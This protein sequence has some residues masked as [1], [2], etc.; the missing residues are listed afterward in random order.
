MKGSTAT[1]ARRSGREFHPLAVLARSLR[2]GWR[3]HGKLHER[4]CKSLTTKAVHRHRVQLRKLMSLLDL[5]SGLADVDDLGKARRLLKR[6]HRVTRGLRDAQVGLRNIGRLPAGL[7]GAPEFAEWLAKREKRSARRASKQLKTLKQKRLSHL[8]ESLESGL[9][10]KTGTE[11]A[12]RVTR[13]L[14]RNVD[15][16]FERFAV[17]DRSVA[18][19]APEAIHSARVALKRCAYMTEE[20]LPL[21]EGRNAATV[22]SLREFTAVMGRIQDCEALMAALERYE[23]KSRKPADSHRGLRGE[24]KRSRDSLIAEYLRARRASGTLR[25]AA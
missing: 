21:L 13:R 20:T 11:G 6:R 5:L 1:A 14:Q 2:R 19:E 3:A 23:R 25:A 8:M 10:R 22:A 9:R 4:C 17:R 7:T 18:A 16:A 15:R 12:G 24:L